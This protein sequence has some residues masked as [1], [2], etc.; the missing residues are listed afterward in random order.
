MK[1]LSINIGK[2][3]VLRTKNGEEITGILKTPV[4]GPMQI[5]ELGIAEDFI[6]SPK[7]HGGPDQALYIYGEADYQ[8]WEK[9][10]GQKLAPGIFGENLTIRGIENA[11]VNVGDY[12]Y[13]GDVALQVSAPR[14][15]CGTFASHMQD[16]QWVKKFRAAE[17]PG[18]YCRVLQT[19]TITAGD[20][21]RMEKFASET[22]SIVEVY[23]DHY[24][25]RG[26]ELL[27]RQLNAPISIRLRARLERDLQA[28]PSKQP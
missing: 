12:L 6:G 25:K 2:E 20:D 11:S 10:L 21:V 15:P 16:P 22:I 28:V 8:W 14:I 9:E 26:E 5:T 1:L 13:I 17:R 24:E 23:R 18:F 19:G 4:Q 3:K 7:H 27:R